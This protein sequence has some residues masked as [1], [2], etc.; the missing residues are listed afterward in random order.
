[1]AEPDW[2]TKT[3]RARLAV[4]RDLADALDDYASW[5]AGTHLDKPG[6]GHRE[7]Q[8]E[9]ADIS[10]TLTNALNASGLPPTAAAGVAEL[11]GYVNEG[12]TGGLQALL[13]GSDIVKGRPVR[14]RVL[15][16]AGWDQAD[17]EENR[18]GQMQAI[19]EGDKRPE[20]M[21][22]LASVQGAV[23]R[24]A[25]GLAPLG[26]LEN[27]ATDSPRM[28]ELGFRSYDQLKRLGQA[29]GLGGGVR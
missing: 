7:A 17:V 13:A 14:H 2:Y 25:P 4:R 18:K 15:G 22:R 20:W 5:L 28:A 10:R 8:G 19:R 12:V 26:A 29:L 27:A 3:N 24:F 1:M 23:A 21:R 9:H 11:G 6:E 16:P